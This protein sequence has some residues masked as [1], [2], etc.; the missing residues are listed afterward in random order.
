MINYIKAVNQK[1]INWY[2][3]YHLKGRNVKCE[4][5]NWDG[6][7]FLD[8]RCPKCRSLARTRLIPFSINYFQLNL[9]KTKILHIAPNISEYK[10]VLNNIKFE[11]YDRL[12]IVSASHVNLIQDLTNMNINSNFYDQIIAWHVL[13]HIPNDGDAIKE[14]FRVLKKGGKLLLSVPIYPKNNPKTIEIP[15]LPKKQY[16]EVHGHDD[17]CRSCGL[18]YFSR[19]EAVGFKTKTLKVLDID[20]AEIKRFGLSPSHVVWCFTK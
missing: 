7:R 13:E 17:H 9:N 4:L 18:D 6:E 19:F 20:K 8:N 16:E 3:V 2:N 1:I 12:N 14:M 15:N 10:Y 5:C 11:I